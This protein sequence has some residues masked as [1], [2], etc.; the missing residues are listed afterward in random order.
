MISVI[1]FNA[2]YSNISV[3]LWQSVLLVDETGGNPEKNTDLPQDTYKISH[4]LV[5]STPCHEQCKN[6]TNQYLKVK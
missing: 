5:W 1:I 2:T 4:N 6:I 3:I